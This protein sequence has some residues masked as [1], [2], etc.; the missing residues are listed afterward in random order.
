MLV[1]VESKVREV[2]DFVADRVEITKFRIFGSLF[3]K[4]PELIRLSELIRSEKE[5]KQTINRGK[6]EKLLVGQRAEFTKL[7]NH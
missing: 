3:G 7:T 6:F 4:S 1:S 2:R 5:F